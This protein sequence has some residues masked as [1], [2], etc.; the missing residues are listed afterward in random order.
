MPGPHDEVTVPGY[1]PALVPRSRLLDRLGEA[2]HRRLTLVTAA[3][4]LGKTTLL[5][6]WTGDRC[7]AWFTVGAADRD[8]AV[9][10]RG[11]LEAVR[12]CVPGLDPAEVVTTGPATITGGGLAVPASGQGSLAADALVAV[13]TQR[14]VDD[15]TLVVDDVHHLAGAEGTA[16]L[17]ADLVRSGPARLHL[18]L[19]SRTDPPFGVSRLRSQGQVLDITGAGLRYTEAET[20]ALM[21]SVLGAADVAAAVHDA[22]GGW[23]AGV[24]IVADWL[25]DAPSDRWAAM[26]AQAADAGTPLEAFLVEEVLPGT[27]GA[28]VD[29]L[30]AV[31]PLE[32]FTPPQVARIL[33]PDADDLVRRVARDGLWIVPDR[34]GDHDGWFVVPPLLRR[35]VQAHLAVVA[36]DGAVMVRRAAAWLEGRGED[37]PFTGLLAAA[38]REEPAQ[39]CGEAVARLIRGDFDGAHALLGPCVGA[40]AGPLSMSAGLVAGLVHHFRGELDVAMD[41][42]QRALAAPGDDALRAM[43]LAWAATVA[44]LLGDVERCH[45]LTAE[46]EAA[47]GRSGDDRAWAMACTAR[48]MAA[49]LVG[50]R[51]AMR[52]YQRALTHAEAA[53]DHFQIVRIRNNRGSRFLNEGSY[54]EA[55]VELDEAVRLADLAGIG[56]LRAVALAN[57]G[58]ALLG[59]GRLDEAARELEAAKADYEARGS[60]MASYPLADL[61]TVHRLQGHLT[62]AR[63]YYEEAISISDASG[64]HQGLVPALAGLALTVADIDCEEAERLTA[65]ALAVPSLARPDALLAAAE[66][67]LRMGERTIA[68]ARAE[69][70][71]AAA[72][73][74]YDRPAL[75]DALELQARLDGDPRTAAPLLDEA[76]ALWASIGSPLGEARVLL[77]RATIGCPGAQAAAAE[78]ERELGRLGARTLAGEAAR[79]QADLAHAA[80]PVLAVRVLGGFGVERSGTPIATVEWQSRKARD[81]LK[82]LVARRGRPVPRDVLID[83]LWEDE[84]PSKAGSKLSVTLST[85]RSVL[86]PDKRFEAEHFVANDR[87]AAWIRLDNVTVDVEAFLADARDGLRASA[88]GNPGAAVLLA[89][90]E[91]AYAGEFLEEDLYADWSTILREEAR[92]TYLSVAMALADLTLAAGDHDGAG[93]YL[94]RVLARDA[95]D[96]RAHLQLV[97]ALRGAGRHGEARRMYRTYCDRMADIG[98]EP[99][100]FPD[101]GPRRSSR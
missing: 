99:A 87:N 74:R 30:R 63:T 11:L 21:V 43:V 56:M 77:A 59:L 54:R 79:V 46:S 23:P 80:R 78:A 65:R 88:A 37:R 83:L 96:E 10:A 9:L 66:A 68:G 22:T 72:R 70:A 50:D 98:V 64:D 41:F 48:G 8:P 44:W 62:L 16:Q 75:A 28:V 73:A 17:L 38:D 4:G 84:D 69:E 93:R 47:A 24:R 36:D 92:T 67:A 82:I 45:R 20:A 101:A 13:L 31:V 85:L 61:G 19:A 95:Y 91:A 29:L 25:Q 15:L 40:D 12:V 86:D 90:A 57:R 55:L 94:L 18:V 34:N 51:T 58:H 42:Y 2:D 7:R 76:A 1:R 3:A 53:H 97:A 33:G 89:Q 14:V 26:V 52:H 71:S 100:A 35:F 6:G 81:L 5:A 39:A 49:A 27:S 60:R 32:R